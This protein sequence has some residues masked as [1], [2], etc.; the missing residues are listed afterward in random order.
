MS[1]L[2]RL[3]MDISVFMYD[4]MWSQALEL[5]QP[6]RHTSDSSEGWGSRSGSSMSATWQPVG[7]SWDG[8][9]VLCSPWGWSTS[10]SEVVYY[11]E[12]MWEPK[13]MYY[14][15]PM[16]LLSI[17]SSVSHSLEYHCKEYTPDDK[18][19]FG[20]WDLSFSRMAPGFSWAADS[21]PP[22][23]LPSWVWLSTLDPP[24]G[25]PAAP[26]RAGDCPSSAPA[27]C[28]VLPP[29]PAHA[30][31]SVEC[32]E[33]SPLLPA[34]APAA[35][36]PLV[37]GT[38]RAGCNPLPLPRGF[39]FCRAGVIGLGDLD[40]SISNCQSS[41]SSSSFYLFIYLLGWWMN[42][43]SSQHT[44]NIH[45]VIAK[46]C[47]VLCRWRKLLALCIVTHVDPLH[48]VPHL[49]H[50]HSPLECLQSQCEETHQIAKMAG[51][52]R[53][54]IISYPSDSSKE[55]IL[56]PTA[57]GRALTWKVFILCFHQ[58]IELVVSP[59]RHCRQSVVMTVGWALNPILRLQKL[60]SPICHVKMRDLVEDPGPPSWSLHLWNLFGCF[61]L[62]K[63][64]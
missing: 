55:D 49:P 10:M 34:A 11:V 39:F 63:K 48:Q 38:N 12:K 62:W 60:L 15:S 35:V 47:L 23:S 30:V 32:P 59:S 42:V 24:A 44:V 41:S 4:L 2:W 46:S 40:L 1:P 51:P 14:H 18:E 64:N 7:C 17:S 61:Q 6:I 56:T 54:V 8:S 29:L 19:G 36:V 20:S 58:P 31:A 27:T 25:F 52:L 3:G 50:P 26:A 5:D 13:A 57:R 43:I 22:L 33:A 37:W 16:G 53:H 21:S 28:S 45:T 9:G